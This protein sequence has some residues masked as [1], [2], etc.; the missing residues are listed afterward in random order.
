[1]GCIEAWCL[2]LVHGVLRLRHGN[3][4]VHFEQSFMRPPFWLRWIPCRSIDYLHEELLA[5]N[6][7]SDLTESGF[8]VVHVRVTGDANPEHYIRSSPESMERSKSTSLEIS[9]SYPSTPS[10]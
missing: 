6:K 8:D 1:M 2:E 10:R 7:V 4:R 3:L 9:S 5:T